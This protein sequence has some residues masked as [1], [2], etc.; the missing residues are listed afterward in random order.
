MEK[1]LAELVERC[2]KEEPVGSAEIDRLCLLS[3]SIR[4]QVYDLIAVY[5]AREFTSGR[6]RFD[7]ADAVANFLWAE[8]AFSLSGFAKDV[9]LAFDDGEFLPSEDSVGTNPVEKY[10]RPQLLD[11]LARSS[12]V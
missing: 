10:T 11:L 1:Y 7:D 6:L 8:S 12:L 9:F 5:I 2:A 4:P 3:H